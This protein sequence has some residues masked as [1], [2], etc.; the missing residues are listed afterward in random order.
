MILLSDVFIF[1]FFQAED[2]IRDVAVTGVQTCALP[3]SSGCS[4]MGRTGRPSMENGWCEPPP[5]SGKES[6]VP[7]ARTPGS[8]RTRCKTSWKKLISPEGLG[9]LSAGKI[10]RAHV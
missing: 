1:F 7:A 4:A 6:M 9:N 8:A 3:I 10:G 2:G 5:P